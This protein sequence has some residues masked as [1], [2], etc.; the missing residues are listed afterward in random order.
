[1]IQMTQIQGVGNESLVKYPKIF[2]LGE[3]ENEGI[4]TEIVVI[5]S[6]IDG[7]N[8]RGRYISEKECFIY[9]SRSKLLPSDTNPNQWKAIQSYNLALK[10]YKDAIIPD[11]MYCSES[12]QKHTLHYENIPPTI[13]FDIFDLKK[14]TF[15]PWRLAKKAFEDIGIP[16]INV[17]VEKH[18]S[19]L[20]LEELNELIK[21]SPYRK[22]GDEGIVIKCY[23]R[24]NIFNC[25]LF[26][27]IVTSDFKEKNKAV[28]GENGK[29]KKQPKDNEIK[30]ADTYLTD[31]R[32]NK[33]I[34]R[35]I[36]DGES[37]D[38]GLMPKLYRYIMKDILSEN[39]IEIS[40]DYSN[41]NFPMLTKIVASRCANMLKS[42]LLTKAK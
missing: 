14:M 22:E 15:Y 6:K 33:A 28:F 39:I 38:M 16:F 30:I 13:G 40:D 31:A 37:I 8:F 19:K 18:G 35:F 21:K 24:L 4:L 34:L 25:P 23:D 42:Y 26:A 32:F 7:A 17:H 11:V 10:E 3:E 1:M 2:S 29:S 20:T 12:L 41:I 36:D 5:Q 9:G 27:K